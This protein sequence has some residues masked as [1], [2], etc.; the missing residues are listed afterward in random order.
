MA[1]T[2]IER[3][4]VRLVGDA[5]SYQKMLKDA[6][7]SSKRAATTIQA[8]GLKMQALAGHIKSVG[9]SMRRLG[10]SLAV[11]INAPLTIFGGLAVRAFA[12]FDQ[13]MTEST[14]IMKVTEDQTKRM[15]DTAI[16]LS[17]RV[18]QSPKELAESYFFLASAGLDAEQAMAALPQVAEF[19]TA[20]AFDMALATD[21]LTDAQTAL[22]LSSD[23]TAQNLKNLTRVAD[24][25][26]KANQ[27]ANTSVQQVAEAMTA[28]AGTA[29]RNMG[30]SLETTVA[31]LD[32]YASAGKKGA[33][34][35]N[36]FGRATR[37]LTKAAREN[38]KVFDKFGIKVINEAT[39]EYRNFIDI[40]ADMER[41]FKGLTKPQRDL[42]L[43]QLGF[44]ALAQKSITPL[45]GLSKVMKGYEKTLLDA[46]GATKEV[47]DKQM[48]SFT[49][50]MK[51]LKNQITIVG[52]EIGEILAP[53]LTK[54]SDLL[55]RGTAF[56]KELSLEVKKNTVTVLLIV[57]A[58]GPL[59]ITMGGLVG[60]LGF[61]VSGISALIG[62]VGALL[63]PV[64]L[65]TA[66]VVAFGGWVM[67]MTGITKIATEFLSDSFKKVFDGVGKAIKAGEL[68][69][70]MKIMWEGLKEVWF[71]GLASINEATGG[72]LTKMVQGF[73]DSFKTIA[74]AWFGTQQFIAKKIV[75]ARTETLKKNIAAVTEIQ[76]EG[77]TVG[78]FGI[79]SA[80]TPKEK[81]SLK[82]RK[83]DLQKQLVEAKFISSE[84]VKI[85]EGEFEKKFKAVDAFFN[86]NKAF[87]SKELRDREAA[88]KAAKAALKEEL[89]EKI[90][91]TQKAANV[92]A[93]K[94]AAD[95]GGVKLPVT[96]TID[97][98]AIPKIPTITAP[99]KFEIVK[100]V[101]VGSAE[102]LSRIAEFQAGAG[103]RRV[104]TKIPKMKE[105]GGLDPFRNIP[106]PGVP[107]IPFLPDPPEFHRRV[108]SRPDV[109]M[110]LPPEG[111]GIMGQSV[112][113]LLTDIR[114]DA[115]D[116]PGFDE[117]A[118]SAGL[119]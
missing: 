7:K 2:E 106:I 35:G 8:A 12:Q 60:L 86:K 40:I 88:A 6:E 15:R 100:G 110:P 39:G 51:L 83:I 21:L 47:A 75:T 56:W 24:V 9:V 68:K 17:G 105:P 22:G 33:E 101:G 115:R 79:K 72:W 91:A 87:N 58:V 96:P 66:A 81:E 43:E 89:D 25:F 117:V 114:D 53:M 4:L 54:L 118:E 26:V 65:A 119:E 23:D 93:A 45:L 98:D 97:P 41:S 31:I 34:A 55:Q 84:A 109:A 36:L 11:R 44:A 113:D 70:A 94:A 62:V 82:A 107:D 71:G 69:I 14:S 102:D 95:A 74:K 104:S 1:T 20:G 76:K 37:L 73:L 27:S 18:V 67:W 90:L 3:L 19:A 38:G 52:I 77:T 103:M 63:S 13:A 85:L 59:L 28:D 50:Q 116:K 99:V 10:R 32:A 108:P 61:A 48:K 57:A 30:Q 92:A 29:S 112:I 42:R 5:T 111:T 64:V 16:S 46:G 49:N 78:I 80:L